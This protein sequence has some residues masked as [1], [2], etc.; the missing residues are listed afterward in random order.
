[1]VVVGPPGISKRVGAGKISG[2]LKKYAVLQQDTV[3]ICTGSDLVGIDNNETKNK[4]RAA[5]NQARGGVLLIEQ[6]CSLKDGTLE[7]T[8]VLL[9][10]VQSSDFKGRLLVVL[11]LGCSGRME[12]L[13]KFVSPEFRDCFDK[14][15]INLP[16]WTGEQAT[17]AAMKQIER[18]GIP[19]AKDAQE[20]LARCNI[21]RAVPCP[22]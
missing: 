2:L 1:M 16:Q 8:S 5:L 21:L 9:D 13:F 12:E 7:V 10:H 22:H 3:T 15:R 4:V 6:A 19:I 18:I 17:L 20:E 14:R 11:G